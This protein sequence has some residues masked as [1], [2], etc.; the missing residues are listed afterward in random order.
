MVVLRCLAPPIALSLRVCMLAPPCLGYATQAVVLPWPTLFSNC[1][2]HEH[3]EP[4][5]FGLGNV[6]MGVIVIKGRLGLGNVVWLGVEAA[7][8]PRQDAYR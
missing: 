2:C 8:L 4:Q 6:G 7:P 1:V 5:S 3:A